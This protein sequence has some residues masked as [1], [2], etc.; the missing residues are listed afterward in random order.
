[1]GVRCRMER[2]CSLPWSPLRYR[3][4]Q[5]PC[6]YTSFG[7]QLHLYQSQRRILEYGCSLIVVT[8]VS[9]NRL[10][11]FAYFLLSFLGHWVVALS[12]LTALLLFLAHRC[13]NL[14]SNSLMYWSRHMASSSLSTWL[15]VFDSSFSAS[16]S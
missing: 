10:K 6:Q 2:R 13:A 5:H 4:T 9:V 8:L 14:L 3:Y 15:R 16:S 7:F 11:T 1:M 12:S